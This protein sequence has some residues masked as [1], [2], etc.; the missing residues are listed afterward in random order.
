MPIQDIKT[1]QTRFTRPVFGTITICCH[2]K[3]V[4]TMARIASTTG[5]RMKIV[6]ISFLQNV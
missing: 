5:K 6:M 4:A 3:M 1:F 2:T